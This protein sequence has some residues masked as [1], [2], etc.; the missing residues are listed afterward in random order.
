MILLVEYTYPKNRKVSCQHYAANE[1]EKH[2]VIENYIRRSKAKG[3]RILE[4]RK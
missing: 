4:E 1:S 2:E 3:Y